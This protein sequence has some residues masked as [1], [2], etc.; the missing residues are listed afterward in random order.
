MKTKTKI[1][2]AHLIGKLV[3]VRTFSAGVHI[4]LLA[5]RT[6]KTLR[7]MDARRLWRWQGANSLSEVASRGVAIPYTRLSEPVEVVLMEATEIIPV[8]EAARASLTSS[9]W[10]S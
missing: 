8:S 2:G 5:E 6:G 9:R 3:L 4:G 10:G 7:L 1:I